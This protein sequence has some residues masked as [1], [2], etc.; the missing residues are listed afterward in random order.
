MRNADRSDGW[1][2]APPEARI[3]DLHQA[4]ADDGVQVVLAGIGGNHS[5]QLLPLLDYELIRA[6]PKV[7]QGFSDITVLQWAIAKH[8]GLA[9]FYGPALTT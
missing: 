2:S 1:A 9:T 5:N 4:F 3:E 7:F 6:H 8:A